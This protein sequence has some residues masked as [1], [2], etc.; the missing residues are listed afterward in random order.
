MPSPRR[1]SRRAALGLAALVLG[2]VPLRAQETSTPHEPFFRFRLGGELSGTLGPEDNGFFNDVDYGRN[3]LRLFRL[4][5][6]GELQAGRRLALL[7]EVRS[8][9]LDAP[10]A[11]GL[12]LRVTP[13]PDH[14]IDL[15]VGRIPP[16]FGAFARRRYGQDNP[17]IATPLLY[18]YLTTVR[19]DAVP[20]NA[21]DMLSQ[22]GSGWLVDYPVGSPEP[23]AGLPIVESMRWDTGAELRLGERPVEWSVSVTRGSLG[24]PRTSDDNGGKQVATRLG[25]Y[26]APGLVLGASFADGAYLDDQVEALLPATG[27]YHQRAFGVD[28]EYAWDRF[29]VR[30]E[31]IVG[32]WRMPEIDAPP[33]DRPLDFYGGFVEG[34]YRILPGLHVAARV[35]H[36]D[37]GTLRGSAT[38]DTWDAHVTRIEAGAGYLLRRNVQLKASFQHDWR[39][40]GFVHS[41]S[42]VSGQ[43][44]AWF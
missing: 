32:H 36:L 15:Q 9:N 28:A 13:L 2:A 11:Y 5:L 21:D 39:D 7:A 30:G 34:R 23:D 35:D 27:R 42:F 12:Y 38:T 4:S 37:F 17:L 25:F 43:V 26:P 20:A 3:A 16:V 14:P 40:G 10:R 31:G 33:I 22:R 41:E 24:N 29:V 18:Q 19:P 1:T 6:L 44:L 8:E